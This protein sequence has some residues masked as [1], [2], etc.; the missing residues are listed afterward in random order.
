MP[1]LYELKINYG[2][3]PPYHIRK[4]NLQTLRWF[5]DIFVNSPKY[6]RLKI[7]IPSLSLINSRF[8]PSVCVSYG[9]F[10]SIPCLNP[11]DSSFLNSK[12]EIALF[13]SSMM[14]KTHIY[15]VYMRLHIAIT[16]GKIM[17]AKIDL[18]LEYTPTVFISYFYCGLFCDLSYVYLWA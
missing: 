7:R 5:F 9:L 11:H 8:G 18:F 16:L 14:Y 12:L 6:F 2:L 3:A 13:R 15:S 1:K 4:C 10:F 17:Q